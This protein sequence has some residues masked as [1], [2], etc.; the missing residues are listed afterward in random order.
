MSRPC[1]RCGSEHF[2]VQTPA[3]FDFDG[4]H[5]TNTELRCDVEENENCTEFDS[6]TVTC[7]NCDWMGTVKELELEAET[8]GA[9][10]ILHPEQYDKYTR[11]QLLLHIRVLENRLHTIESA[12]SHLPAEPTNPQ[13]WPRESIDGLVLELLDSISSIK[14]ACPWDDDNEAPGFPPSWMIEPRCPECGHALDH[15]VS[16]DPIAAICHSPGCEW[17]G[18]KVPGER[19]EAV[20]FDADADRARSRGI[21]DGWRRMVADKLRGGRPR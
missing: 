11:T 7:R 5:I 3:V 1:P 18:P 17:L 20:P 8:P 16:G 15:F 9:A 13:S 14:E 6:A 10:T 4:E 2:F 19:P 12:I 21:V